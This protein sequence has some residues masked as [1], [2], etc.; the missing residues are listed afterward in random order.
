ML[1]IEVPSR[2]MTS[3][4]DI[5]HKETKDFEYEDIQCKAPESKTHV[6]EGMP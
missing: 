6:E 5:G 3:T 4:N 2:V 1:G